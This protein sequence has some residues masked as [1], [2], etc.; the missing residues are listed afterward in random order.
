MRAPAGAPAGVPTCRWGIRAASEDLSVIFGLL[1][2]VHTSYLLVEDIWN[3]WRASKIVF[4][5]VVG[6]HLVVSVF[7]VF[8]IV[9]VAWLGCA[10]D[11]LL[12]FDWAKQAVPKVWVEGSEEMREKAM[13]KCT[14]A[15]AAYLWMAV[16]IFGPPLQQWL[17][18]PEL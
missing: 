13:K 9:L 10:K 18:W 6:S 7:C 16:A 1:F 15:C 5:A 3:L 2:P 8:K 14:I 4:G 17:G 11:H 12:A